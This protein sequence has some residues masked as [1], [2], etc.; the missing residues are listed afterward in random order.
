MRNWIRLLTI[1]PLTIIMLNTCGKD[2]KSLSKATI[3]VISHSDFLPD[4]TQLERNVMGLPDVL[5]ERIIEHLT[6]SKRFIPVERQALRKVVLEQR[7]GKDLSKTYL[8]RTLDEAID[9]MEGISGSQKVSGVETEL[10]AGPFSIK[11]KSAV[12]PRPVGQG[13][14]EG[15]GSVGATGTLAN[16]NDILKDFQD[17]GTAVGADYLV[18]GKLEKLTRKTKEIDVPYSDEGRKFRKNSV[19]ARLRLRVIDVKSGT[20]AGAT[21]LRTKVEES[22]FEGKESDTD[23]YSFY[24]HLGRLASVK[25]LDVTFPARIA[26]TDPLV[27]SR[28]INDGVKKGDIYTIERE[29]KEIK[30]K[31]GIVIGRLKTEVGQAKVD[32][33]QETISVVTPISG[34]KFLEGDLASLNI[35][36]SEA[37]AP[38]L[39]E[40][41]V[42]LKKAV[43][44]SAA[45][46]DLP[47]VA[48]G[49]I[50]S[51]STARTGK[52]AAEH[53]PIF[54]D[55][56]I[57]RLTQTRR[58]QM[59]DRQ[60]V[61]QLLD[62]QLL[63]AL[64]E[65]R[66]LPS[67]VGTL[68][69]VD[70]LVY[71]S[72][73]SFSV[74]DKEI[75]L[76]NS[77]RTFKQKIGYVEGNIRVVDA[78]SSDIMESRKISVKERVETGAKGTRVVTAL[79]D[80]YAEHVVLILMNNIYPIKVAAVGQ[81]GTV[82]VN[83]GDDGGL[84]AGET[85]DAFR[86]GKP[87]ID[88]D[89]GVQLGVEEELIGQVSIDEVEDARSKCRIVT[90]AGLLKGDILKRTGENK[91]K[92]ASKALTP[93]PSRT[94]QILP[95]SGLSADK[96]A[97]GSKATI[98][99]GLIRLNSNARTT[100]FGKG[101][102]KRMTDDFIVKL[103]NTNRFVL[104][105]RQEV[106]QIIDEKAFEAV[107]SGGDILDRLRELQGADYLIH[108][109]VNNFYTTTK[110]EK[111]PYLDEEQVRVEGTAEGTF[112]IVDIY[113]GT[114]IAADKVS[115]RERIKDAKDS[116][117]I[118]SNL[119][120]KFTTEAVGK[121]V[122]R[123]YPIKLLGLSG[124]GT[125][126]L[127][128]GEDGG[129]KVGTVFEVMRP[130]DLLIDPDTKRSF[131]KAETKIGT[132]KIVAVEDYRARAKMISGQGAQKGDILR[133]SQVVTKK[134]K[135]KVLEPEW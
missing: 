16:Y 76:P 14:G 116:T 93:G 103:S 55:T 122:D 59:M 43:A 49:L 2:N 9:S 19:D 56:I 114:V 127:N 88:P 119:I 72:L 91:G 126:Y 40:S 77:N 121:I 5:A 128:R 105:E 39:T 36:A 42:P 63:Q 79:A 100:N 58:F 78:R 96:K 115:I 97:A 18:F 83:R 74:E 17:L 68:K 69:G 106:D 38:I 47:R 4:R 66:D 108:G 31:A 21:S 57:S 28:G 6:N 82:Y 99:V 117:R 27:I 107:A 26:S 50:K 84:F 112:R 65:N 8:D 118:V 13:L 90:G 73:A 15:E 132:L 34:D 133:K 12:E 102:I 109:E 7:F 64:R 120:D 22:L 125:I 135:P 113:N 81:D 61:D 67:A 131:G 10:S 51:G 52:D 46:V 37:S 54:T 75:R 23:C 85:L 130:G 1:I 53:T 110:R 94:G 35:Q 20:V 129:L 48:L 44:G 62:E 80:A 25:V 30:D 95:G 41:V 123:I 111:V 33:P 71:G 70:Y 32:D 11:S 45:K 24:D 87:V 60:E 134:E 86:P 124:D 104:M 29:G 101:H 3:A 92:R 98:A 89:T